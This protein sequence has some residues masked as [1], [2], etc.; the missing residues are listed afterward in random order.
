[1][2]FC[3]VYYHIK[4]R[5]GLQAPSVSFHISEPMLASVVF[6]SCSLLQMPPDHGLRPTPSYS[7]LLIALLFLLC[8]LLLFTTPAPFFVFLCP[9]L[10][11]PPWPCP[12]Y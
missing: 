11:P 4:A 8:S 3:G 5:A 7:F 12:V 1:M 6:S 9:P 10:L 2:P